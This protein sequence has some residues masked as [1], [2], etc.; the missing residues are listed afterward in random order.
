VT[1]DLVVF[2]GLELEARREFIATVS[3][4]IATTEGDVH[5]DCSQLDALDESTLGMLVALAR[6]AQRRGAVLV[7]DLSTKRTRSDL[8]DVGVSQMFAWPV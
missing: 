3:S 8:D 7:L 5:L 6:A 2:G 1:A 4:V